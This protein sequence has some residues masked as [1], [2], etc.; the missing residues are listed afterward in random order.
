M[1]D[2]K[3]TPLKGQRSYYK[4]NAEL[5]SLFESYDMISYCR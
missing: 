5:A 4:A 3:M 1:H 2:V